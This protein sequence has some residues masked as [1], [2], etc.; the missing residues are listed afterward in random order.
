MQRTL[1][2]AM[3]SALIKSENSVSNILEV[4]GDARGGEQFL[5]NPPP[6][7]SAP[8]FPSVAARSIA[9]QKG[10]RPPRAAIQPD[11]SSN[12]NVLDAANLILGLK[13]SMVNLSFAA[14][15]RTSLAFVSTLQLKSRIFKRDGGARIPK[16]LNVRIST[17]SIG[18]TSR[19]RVAK[20]F[21][22]NTAL[23]RL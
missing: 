20:C 22:S 8:A 17:L 21:F 15:M 13:K 6:G 23:V 14:P 4:I 5:I 18:K 1:L 3:L 12:A 9:I 10:T 16:G 11:P 19:P 7:G 2:T